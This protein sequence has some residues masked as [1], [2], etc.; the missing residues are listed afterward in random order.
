MFALLCA[1]SE[2]KTLFFHAGCAGLLPSIMFCVILFSFAAIALLDLFLHMFITG[3]ADAMTEIGAASLGDISLNLNPLPTAGL[4]AG[5]IPDFLTVGAYWQKA[6]ENF[7][8][9]LFF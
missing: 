6:F 8:A 5:V 4:F 3:R 9:L 2:E 1:E 7:N